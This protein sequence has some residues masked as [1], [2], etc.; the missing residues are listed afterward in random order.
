[1]NEQK[2]REAFDEWADKEIGKVE[3][4]ATCNRSL[5]QALRNI[6]EA[7]WQAAPAATQR[8]AMAVAEAVRE[9]CAKRWH[10]HGDRNDD[11]D[12]AAIVEAVRP[13]AKPEPLCSTCNA[14]GEH[15]PVGFF[16]GV[17]ASGA[18]GRMKFSVTAYG[19]LPMA[20]AKLYIAP[21]A[22][23]QGEPVDMPDEQQHANW[24]LLVSMYDN[25]TPVQQKGAS[26]MAIEVLR[27]MLSAAPKGGA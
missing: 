15:E 6:A 22:Q 1:M 18:N 9:A 10:R 23:Q 3:H 14:R 19:A 24:Q 2:M 17:F 4:A 12:L 21:P 16:N 8:D 27:A 5:R 7:A 20:G 11:V 25:G 26:G 13:A